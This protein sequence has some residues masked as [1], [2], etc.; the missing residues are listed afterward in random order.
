MAKTIELLTCKILAII[1]HLS[2][3]KCNSCF[4]FI[5]AS[6]SVIQIIREQSQYKTE[7][8]WNSGTCNSIEKNKGEK[9]CISLQSGNVLSSRIML[10]TPD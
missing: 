6:C 7:T 2:H 5:K 3:E 8:M 4:S 9:H 10:V 1:A